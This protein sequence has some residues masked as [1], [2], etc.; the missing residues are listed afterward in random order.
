MEKLYT[1]FISYKSGG[2]YCG[3]YPTLKIARDVIK[4]MLSDCEIKDKCPTIKDISEKIDKGD[5]FW[6]GFNDGTCD[7]T[8]VHVQEVGEQN[9]ERIKNHLQWGGFM[10]FKNK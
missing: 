3:V 4:E 7:F 6:Y 10:N 5:D 8:W 2:H 9:V 1:L